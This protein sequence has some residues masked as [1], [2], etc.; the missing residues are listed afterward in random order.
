MLRH[1]YSL[2]VLI[3]VAVLVSAVPQ[4]VLA[5]EHGETP[6]S[7]N[8]LEFASNTAFW[9]LIIFVIV[10]AVLGKLAFKPIAAALDAREQGITDNIAAA[11]RLQEE[12][13]DLM[14][15]HQDKLDAS[16]DE[17]R[18]IIETAKKD[19][20]RVAEDIVAKAR[21]EAVQERERAA[22]EIESATVSALQAIAERSAALATNLAGR[23]IRA[24]VKPEQHRGLIDAALQDFV[25]S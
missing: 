25:K 20:V 17:V 14:K 5:N 24:E 21:A 16:R 15:Q 22:K 19:A 10:F 4:C 3:A 2:L 8:P 18:Q 1:F 11:Q 6:P 9:S 12:A 13:K 7:L 23:I